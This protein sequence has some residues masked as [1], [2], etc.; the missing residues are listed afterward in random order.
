[1]NAGSP[2]DA[3]PLVSQRHGSVALLT[4]NRPD[5]LNASNVAMLAALDRQRGLPVRCA[6]SALR[7]R[8][9]GDAAAERG[10]SGQRS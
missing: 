1:M 3:T 2:A 4:L 5:K 6:R 7:Q 9:R 10:R 8:H